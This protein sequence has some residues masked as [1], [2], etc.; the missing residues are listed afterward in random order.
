[1]FWF[2]NLKGRDDLEDLD[3]DRKIILEWTLWRLDRR[4]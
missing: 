1:M 2:E 4:V 3:V